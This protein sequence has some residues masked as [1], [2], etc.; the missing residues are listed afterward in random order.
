[1]RTLIT[2]EANE[3]QTLA[4]NG[5]TQIK[6]ADYAFYTR[7]NAVMGAAVAATPARPDETI[8]LP[9]AIAVPAMP[10]QPARADLI[11]GRARQ[12][13]PRPARHR[14]PELSHR[15]RRRAPEA[16]SVGG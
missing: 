12:Q 1:M 7:G 15:H 3:L 11:Q 14:Q 13:L 5:I 4:Q 2:D 16:R 6:S 9:A 8:G 10:L